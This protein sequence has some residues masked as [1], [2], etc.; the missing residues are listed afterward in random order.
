MNMERIEE[1]CLNY[2]RQSSNPLVPVATLAEYCAREDRG[3]GVSR[4][5]LLHFLRK[6]GEV[7]VMEG[8]S[9]TEAIG[10]DLF[11]SAGI[12]MGPRV[13]LNTRVPTPEEMAAMLSSQ[14]K[15]MLDVLRPAIDVAEKERDEG[16]VQALK[17]A[18]DRAEG[19]DARIAA[20]LRG[21]RDGA[22]E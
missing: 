10:Q 2:L 18:L 5:E 6:H 3:S 11:N 14:V 8:P 19:M 15:A 1:L 20:A 17:S 12:D 7:Q 21:G 9:E 4:D 22:L 16:R 13:I